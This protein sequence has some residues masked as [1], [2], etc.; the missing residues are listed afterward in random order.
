MKNKE[1]VYL[2]HYFHNSTFLGQSFAYP[3]ISKKREICQNLI[4]LNGK[5]VEQLQNTVIHLPPD[6]L[7]KFNSKAK[8]RVK[9]I[10]FLNK[11]K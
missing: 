1:I 10:L 2:V 11:Q 3:K 8:I 7:V 4:D 6:E 5:T 9:Q